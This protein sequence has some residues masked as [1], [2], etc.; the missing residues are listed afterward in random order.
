MSSANS[1]T[2]ASDAR[3]SFLQWTFLLKE[4]SMISC[5]ASS[6]LA[7]SRQAIMTLPPLTAIS[8]AVS[9]PRPQLAPVTITVLPWSF[10]SPLYLWPLDVSLK[11]TY[12]CQCILALMC[13]H[14]TQCGS[15]AF[16]LR[17]F[18]LFYVQTE[19]EANYRCTFICICGKLTLESSQSPQWFQQLFAG[20]TFTVVYVNRRVSLTVYHVRLT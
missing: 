12:T 5:R 9:L 15:F 2:D 13:E 4:D 14:W 7:R 16:V 1:L 20:M 3:S 8:L 18:S 6:H 11:H 17:I 19:L 10:S